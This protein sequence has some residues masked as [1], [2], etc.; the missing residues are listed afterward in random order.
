MARQGL[1]GHARAVLPRRRSAQVQPS[2]PHAACAGGDEARGL[3]EEERSTLG[4]RGLGAVLRVSAGLGERVPAQHCPDQEHP[5]V[6]VSCSRGGGQPGTAD[7][8]VQP[9]PLGVR[10]NSYRRKTRVFHES[11]FVCVPLN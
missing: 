9:P 7:A 11:C 3:W 5:G 2:C 8:E 6:A 10:D 4:F 1:S